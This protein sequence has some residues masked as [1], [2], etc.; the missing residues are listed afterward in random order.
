[1]GGA[2]STESRCWRPRNKPSQLDGESV[3]TDLFTV[4]KA[5]VLKVERIED[6]EGMSR[7][8]IRLFMQQ[9]THMSPETFLS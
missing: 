7:G 2:K 4:W 6:V 9:D 3:L 5:R 1:M 8:D